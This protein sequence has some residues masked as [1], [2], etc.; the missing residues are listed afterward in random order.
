[1]CFQ[2]LTCTVP[3]AELPICSAGNFGAGACKVVADAAG[4]I[5]VESSRNSGL[6]STSGAATPIVTIGEAVESRFPDALPNESEPWVCL[7]G[8][9][10]VLVA[11]ARAVW[12]R[13]K[14]F[15]SLVHELLFTSTL[16]ASEKA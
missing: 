12:K 9:G 8:I 15:R 14:E 5:T 6:W 13:R 10:L 2:A 1:M 3:V 4:S 16:E 11:V 7:G